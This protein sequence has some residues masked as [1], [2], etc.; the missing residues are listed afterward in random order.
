MGGL[1]WRERGFSQ[2]NSGLKSILLRLNS[3]LKNGLFARGV[4]NLLFFKGELFW[5]G[6]FPTGQNPKGRE[7]PGFRR[8]NWR[9][10]RWDEEVPFSGL[11]RRG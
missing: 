4:L 2:P 5:E 11:K 1:I 7:L 3:G 9:P 6:T 8:G 10:R